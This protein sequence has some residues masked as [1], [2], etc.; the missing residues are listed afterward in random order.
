MMLMTLRAI[1][2]LSVGSLTEDEQEIAAKAIEQGYLL[3]KG[4]TLYTKILVNNSKDSERLYSV[5][6]KLENGYFDEAAES[7]AKEMAA[8]IKNALPDYL[9][10]EWFF[11]NSLAGLPMVDALVEALIERGILTPPKD[12]IGA[13]GCWMEIEK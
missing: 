10:G 1:N 8:L 13:E 4:N 9:L 5:T 11:A 6:N 12:G 2:G 3:R 7:I